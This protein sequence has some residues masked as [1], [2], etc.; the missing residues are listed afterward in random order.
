[1]EQVIHPLETRMHLSLLTLMGSNVDSNFDRFSGEFYLPS[2]TCDDLSFSQS[3]LYR[4]SQLFQLNAFSF[5]NN[6]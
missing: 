2:N 6:E 3:P 5:K 4:G 1:M